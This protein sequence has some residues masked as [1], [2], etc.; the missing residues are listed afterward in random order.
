MHLY[1]ALA[2][3]LLFVF[4]LLVVGMVDMPYTL[5][6]L[7]KRYE[8]DVRSTYRIRHVLML[9]PSWLTYV[10]SDKVSNELLH[11]QHDARVL[12]FLCHKSFVKKLPNR[13]VP[14]LK[15]R[16]PRYSPLLDFTALAFIF[17]DPPFYRG[18]TFLLVATFL[19]GIST[20]MVV[21]QRPM[22]ARIAVVRFDWIDPRLGYSV[23]FI[24]CILTAH[25]CFL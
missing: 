24:Q 8:G 17:L 13:F 18:Q 15:N 14:I 12:I 10:C 16:H 6:P 1:L 2:T 9:L 11:C 22:M 20:E 21:V 7:I 5:H 3:L 23:V 19:F 4:V 25:C